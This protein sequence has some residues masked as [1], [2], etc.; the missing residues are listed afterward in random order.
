[1]TERLQRT[2]GTRV[3]I[4]GNEKR[5]KIEIEFYSSEELERIL[6]IIAE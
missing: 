3:K 1:V 5:G 2:L 4:K 6:E